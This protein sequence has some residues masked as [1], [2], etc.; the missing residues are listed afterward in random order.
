MKDIEH[1][2]DLLCGVAVKIRNDM[3]DNA[4]KLDELINELY[5]VG[6][7]IIIEYD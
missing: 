1:A 5:I 6:G 3:P 4:R 7:D 2:L